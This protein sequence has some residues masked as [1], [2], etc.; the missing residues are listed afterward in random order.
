MGEEEGVEE[1][2]E[3][4]KFKS[5]L[6]VRVFK[7]LAINHKVPILLISNKIMIFF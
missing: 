1:L 5:P 6:K 4:W 2:K 3:F 7:W